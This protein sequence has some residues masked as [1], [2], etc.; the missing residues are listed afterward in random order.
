VNLALQVDGAEHDSG[1]LLAYRR[2]IS[3]VH[4]LSRLLDAGDL[5]EP[6]D[7]TAQIMSR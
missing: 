6:D 4:W 5:D 7:R 3:G 2:I 1:D